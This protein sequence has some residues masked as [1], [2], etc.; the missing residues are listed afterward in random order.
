MSSYLIIA[1]LRQ[2]TDIYLSCFHALFYI[3]CN[4]KS[5]PCQNLLRSSTIA[6]RCVFAW[7]GFD[8]ETR[9]ARAGSF[10]I[11]AGINH[12]DTIALTAITSFLASR[13]ST[14]VISL[15]A[16]TAASRASLSCDV[17]RCPSPFLSR[18]D[19]TLSLHMCTSARIMWHT[20]DDVKWDMIV[21]TSLC[22]RTSNFVRF[23]WFLFFFTYKSWR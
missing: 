22:R 12:R 3:C 17:S 23:S 13:Y 21:E 4:H 6:R 7:R 20:H 8:V 18:L 10:L 9:L 2:E 11:Q 19:K 16:I 15:R 1:C 14:S 5:F